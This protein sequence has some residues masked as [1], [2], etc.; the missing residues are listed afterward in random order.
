VFN[1]RKD[2]KEYL[3]GTNKYNRALKQ[4]E[5]FNITNTT[6][7]CQ[8]SSLIF[9]NG[10]VAG[11]MGGAIKMK[12]AN[13]ISDCVFTNNYADFVGGAVYSI[14]NAY[15]YIINC[16]FDNN[17]SNS[18]GGAIN[19]NHKLRVFNCV[20]TNNSANT[21]GGA[22]YCTSNATVRDCNFRNNT[23]TTDGA[24]IYNHVSETT[25]SIQNCHISSGLVRAVNY[26]DVGSKDIANDLTT[27]TAGKVL[28]ARQGKALADLIGDAIQYINQ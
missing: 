26:D 5:I 15:N 21:Y 4:G 6:D 28:D 18:E 13:Q 8:I 17:S 23:A 11:N 7:K 24:N 1:T 20:F 9:T 2:V 27:T 14:D 10:Y 12:G 16:V 22:I 3:G 19:S 25:L